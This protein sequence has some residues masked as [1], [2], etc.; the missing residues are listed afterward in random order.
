MVENDSTSCPEGISKEEWESIQ[1]DRIM[2]KSAS[3]YETVFNGLINKFFII[4]PWVTKEKRS[5]KTG[6][7]ISEGGKQRYNY[8][9]DA[10]AL[11]LFINKWCNLKYRMSYDY[12]NIIMWKPTKEE[13][14]ALLKENG[15][16]TMPQ[17]D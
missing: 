9:I 17:Y 8:K 5:K 11:A 12:R 7:I 2:K 10:S 6:E 14:I 4:E 13:E 3:I 1:Q 15:Y 16:K